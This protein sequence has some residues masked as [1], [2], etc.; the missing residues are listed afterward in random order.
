MEMKKRRNRTLKVN[1]D[2]SLNNQLEKKATRRVSPASARMNKKSKK[3]SKRCKAL[4]LMKV[5]NTLKGQGGIRVSNLTPLMIMMVAIFKGNPIQRGLIVSMIIAKKTTRNADEC[6][7]IC[8]RWEALIPT[9]V[10]T[11][12][13]DSINPTNKTINMMTTLHSEIVSSI[14]LNHRAKLRK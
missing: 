12:V 8:C 9:A 14:A 7:K 1:S 6:P 4:T 10:S 2:Q 13:R 5:I 3:I 11:L